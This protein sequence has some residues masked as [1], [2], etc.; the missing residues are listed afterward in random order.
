MQKAQKHREQIRIS[1]KKQL[2]KE[3]AEIKEKQN[4]DL[5]A[6]IQEIKERKAAEKAKDRIEE[7]LYLLECKRLEEAAKFVEEEER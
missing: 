2:E 5:K 7:E 4:A 6:Q 1:R 3:K